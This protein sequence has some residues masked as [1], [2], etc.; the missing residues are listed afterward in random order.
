[1]SKKLE[2]VGQRFGRLTIIEES[3][4]DRRGSVKWLC[5]CDCGIEKV[6]LGTNI[7]AGRIVSCGCYHKESLSKRNFKNLVGQRFGRLVVTEKINQKASNRSNYWK[8]LCDCGNERVVFRSSLV[9]GKTKSCGCLNKERVSE[10]SLKNLAGKR[11]GRLTV[12]SREGSTKNRQSTW[13]CQCDCGNEKIVSGYSLACGDTTSCG[14]KIKNMLTTHG[15][16]KTKEYSRLKNEKRELSKIEWTPEMDRALKKFQKSC[17]VCG[18]INK[19][20][21]DHVYPFSKGYL[22]KPGNAVRLCRSCNSI[23]NDKYPQELDSHTGYKILIAAEL[24]RKYYERQS[25]LRHKENKVQSLNVSNS[26]P[27]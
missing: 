13:K 15:L 16:S 25:G 22:L 12:I 21:V 23:K 1:M 24:F 9:S 3:G 6:I 19:L 10:R 2:L 18:S 26:E 20:C 17:V 8:C 7:V 4:R 27:L 5:Q 11:F 14:C